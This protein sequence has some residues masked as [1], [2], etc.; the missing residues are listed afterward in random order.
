MAKKLF[1]ICLVMAM[2]F[3][4]VGCT[5]VN[6]AVIDEALEIQE[7]KANQRAVVQLKVTNFPDEAEGMSAVISG[8]WRGW[9]GWTSA[10][11]GSFKVSDMTNAKIQDNVATFTL[12]DDKVLNL[13]A[14]MSFEGC[15][16]YGEESEGDIATTAG[17]IKA[18]GNNFSFAVTIDGEGTWVATLDLST[19]EIAVE[20]Q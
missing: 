5:D 1:G 20:K 10:W 12:V 19:G 15:G 9:D 13:D 18:A 11:G 17:E 14:E 16:Y 8:T 6:Q 7:V 2:I 3:A 4:F